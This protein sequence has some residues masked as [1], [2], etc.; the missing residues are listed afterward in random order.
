MACWT[1]RKDPNSTASYRLAGLHMYTLVGAVEVPDVKNRTSA[2]GEST[3]LFKIRNPWGSEVYDGDWS[4]GDEVWDLA[5][6]QTA[7]ENDA[8]LTRSTGSDGVFYMDAETFKGAFSGCRV[9]P[10]NF[11]WHL[12]Q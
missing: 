1:P 12:S 3:L 2:P 8:H 6:V 4:D 11:D 10:L 9:S 7:L 5:E